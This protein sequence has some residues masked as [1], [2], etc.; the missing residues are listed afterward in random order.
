MGSL[1]TTAPIQTRAESTTSNSIYDLPLTEQAIKW[2]HT[3]CGYP[4]KSTLLKA[5]KAGNY[6]GWPMLTEHNIHKYYPETIE[7]A[8]GPLNQM[9]K[10]V[11]ST[12]AKAALLKTCD[13]PISP[14]RKCA[15]C[16]PKRTWY[17]IPCS[18]TK[19]ASSP[20]DLIEAT[21]PSLLWWKSIATPSSLNL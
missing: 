12:K 13:T 8:K 1:V 4:V 6:V 7:T 10:N 15:T 3:I 2:I 16:T 18:L 5:I 19:P 21:S 14:A 11:R 20:P 9:R 17:V